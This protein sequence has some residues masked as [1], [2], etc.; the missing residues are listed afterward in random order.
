MKKWEQQNDMGCVI[1][2]SISCITVN[3]QDQ[4]C[5][6]LVGGIDKKEAVRNCIHVCDI[7]SAFNQHV[8]QLKFLCL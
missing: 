1:L 7:I 2:S 8:V 3:V 4:G 5:V 6:S